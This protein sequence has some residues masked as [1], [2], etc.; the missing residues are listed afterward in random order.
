MTM[1]Y[2][3]FIDERPLILCDSIHGIPA[4]Y[5]NAPLFTKPDEAV[6]ADTLNAL[7]SGKYAAAVL[8]DANVDGLLEQVKSHF[9]TIVAGGGLIVNTD[10]DILLMFRRG[11]WDLPKG[12]LDD[13]ETIEACAVR[14][15]AEETGLH[16][17]TLGDKIAETYHYYSYK[18]Q[19]I[20]KHTFWYKMNFTGTELTI[21]QIEEDIMDIQWIKPAN[22]G[23]Y[24]QYSYENIRAVFAQAGYAV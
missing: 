4:E 1:L 11:K 21:P 7:K 12:K 10:G 14:E 5:L 9:S 17:I 8:T 6:V 18:S 20:L 19:P 16:S 2:T 23:K 24:M 3:I 15:V 22:I 13:G